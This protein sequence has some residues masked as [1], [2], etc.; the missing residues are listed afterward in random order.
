M[1]VVIQC[2]N[3]TLVHAKGSSDPIPLIALASTA[4]VDG[5]VEVGVRD[6][7]FIRVDADDRA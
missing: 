1:L 2:A 6:V 4:R 3:Q 7:D 5:I